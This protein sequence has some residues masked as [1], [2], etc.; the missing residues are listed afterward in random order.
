MTNDNDR[1]NRLIA[2]A[3]E[4]H[5]AVV[6]ETIRNAYRAGF[7]DGIWH[8]LR[9]ARQAIHQDA[10]LAM[11][12][13]ASRE[14]PFT[15]ESKSGSAPRRAPYGLCRRAIAEAFRVSG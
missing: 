4:G 15:A 1:L 10:A 6:A 3:T 5:G 11:P 8:V 13:T 2:K 7:S 9:T 12:A 14:N